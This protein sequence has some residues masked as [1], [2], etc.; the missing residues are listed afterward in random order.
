MS[1][2]VLKKTILIKV[3]M[4]R[5]SKKKI[6]IC[7]PTVF[8]NYVT[9]SFYTCFVNYLYMFVTLFKNTVGKQI[10]IFFRQTFH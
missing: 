7:L 5:L 4:K 1:N 3:S 9:T 10:N 6:F 8:L 2:D